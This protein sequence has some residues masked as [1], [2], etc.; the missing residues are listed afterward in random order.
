MPRNPAILLDR[1]NILMRSYSVRRAGLN[2]VQIQC[3]QSIFVLHMPEMEN[4][5]AIS[6][7]SPQ[8]CLEQ[9][10]MIEKYGSNRQ[11]KL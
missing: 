1:D 8:H 10:F 2:T 11:I 6:R 9:D 5:T 7:I 3:C 4:P